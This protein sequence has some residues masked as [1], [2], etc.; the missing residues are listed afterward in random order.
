MFQDLT[1]YHFRTEGRVDMFIQRKNA[2][3]MLELT[4]E[5]FLSSRLLL[6]VCNAAHFWV[7]CDHQI[8]KSFSVSVKPYILAQISEI[9]II[10]HKKI[11]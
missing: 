10:L 9:K 8:P 6:Q 4:L 1:R 3:P 5:K 7:S 2:T 11:P